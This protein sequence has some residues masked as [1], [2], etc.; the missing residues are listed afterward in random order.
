MVLIFKES[1]FQTILT[2]LLPH[3]HFCLRI[4]HPILPLCYRVSGCSILPILKLTI[5]GY[6]YIL[7]SKHSH[8]LRIS[9]EHIILKL[10]HTSLSSRKS[11]NYI[12]SQHVL[13][14]QLVLIK[15]MARAMSLF[16]AQT[17]LEKYLEQ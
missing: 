15:V 1:S 13:A 7:Q 11:T 6:F 8:Q 10:Y 4:C 5:H 14:L 3:A 9:K 17:R 12:T 16:L 2:K